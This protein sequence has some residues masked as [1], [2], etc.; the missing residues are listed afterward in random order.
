MALFITC[1]NVVGLL[2]AGVSIL[3]G[4]VAGPSCCLCSRF[5]EPELGCRNRDFE[6]GCLVDK[7]PLRKSVS[8]QPDDRAVWCGSIHPAAPENGA[9]AAYFYHHQSKRPSRG[10]GTLPRAQNLAVPSLLDASTQVRAKRGTVMDSELVLLGF[11]S[12]CILRAEQARPGALLSVPEH[13]IEAW[14]LR[15]CRDLHLFLYWRKLVTF[16]IP[17]R[18]RVLS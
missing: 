16:W 18:W 11:V 5:K 2:D 10:R 7:R 12:Y 15:T 8:S 1:W 4:G 9:V 14:Q 6:A 3:R 13:S 17:F